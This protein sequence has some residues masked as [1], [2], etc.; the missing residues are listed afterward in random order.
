MKILL[1]A[2][3]EGEIAPT[4]QY[5]A[6]HKTDVSILITG[7][8]LLAATYSL[9]KA[10]AIQR[11]HLLLQAGIAGTFDRTQTLG[12]VVAVQSETVADLGV[13]EDGN[14]RSLFHLGL[15]DGNTHPWTDEKLINTNG[16]L[17]TCGLP[18]VDGVTVNEISTNKNRMAHYTKAY[19][20]QVESMEGA[21]LHYVGL[22]EAVPFLQLRSL[23]NFVGERDKSR[24]KMKDAIANLNT[25]LQRLL[26]RLTE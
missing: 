14:F 7:V 21:V 8:G 13:E 22:M 11:P 10:V 26:K 4:V 25:E 18:L 6:T 3:T 23:S 17:S 12:S 24:W 2:A 5:L 15:L 19:N 20:A 9:T 1:C 16:I